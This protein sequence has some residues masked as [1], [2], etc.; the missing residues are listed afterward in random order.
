MKVAAKLF[1]IQ[2]QMITI[3][4]TSDNPYFDSKYF[5]IN[6]LVEIVKPLLTEQG[7]LLTQPMTVTE[8]GLQ[9]VNTIITDVES[10]E[11]INSTALISSDANAQKVGSAVS[12]QRRYTLQS[13]LGLQSVDDDGEATAG[14]GKTVKKKAPAAKKATSAKPSVKKLF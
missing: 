11:S 4:K 7:L 5:D 14:R 2:K 13:L 6:K 1:E 10:G 12:Y 9:L 3:A 8:A